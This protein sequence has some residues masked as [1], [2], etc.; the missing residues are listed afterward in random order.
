M[1]VGNPELCGGSGNK[2]KCTMKPPKSVK[3]ASEPIEKF[4]EQS[5]A[6]L[7]TTLA[8]G[9]N[10][11]PFE[12]ELFGQIEKL[13]RVPR[14][15]VNLDLATYYSNVDLFIFYDVYQYQCK[16]EFT[17]QSMLKNYGWNHVTTPKRANSG[18][19]IASKH[20]IERVKLTD[21]S[22]YSFALS[23]ML[24]DEVK[25]TRKYYLIAIKI[26]EMDLR[27]IRDNLLD[28]EKTIGSLIDIIS[29]LKNQ[30][31]SLSESNANQ[32]IPIIYSIKIPINFRLYPEVV[33]F[34]FEMLGAQFH[35]LGDFSVRD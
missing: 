8:I 26:D 5:S 21:L 34:F 28:V 17:L 1:Q 27:F 16:G 14:C 13:C 7:L 19:L 6:H 9:L 31:D 22:K 24:R 23:L 35:E 32:L 11:F 4:S 10:L 29:Q 30:L 3:I 25:P 12:K 18:M 33:A 2:V 15:D 20:A